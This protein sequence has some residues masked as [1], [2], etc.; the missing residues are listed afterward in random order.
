MLVRRFAS[1]EAK[2]ENIKITPLYDL[3]KAFDGRMVDFAG[4]DLPVYYQTGILNEHN[5]TRNL[6]SLFDVSHMAQA[7]IFGNAEA[8][9]KIF[10]ADLVNMDIGQLRYNFLLNDAGGIVDDLMITRKSNTHWG[11]IVNAACRNK[12]FEYLANHF[13]LEPHGDLGLLA[14]QGPKASEVIGELNPDIK[15]LKFM[16]STEANLAGVSVFIS[17]SG[18]TGEDGYEISVSQENCTIL[19]RT[20]LENENVKLAGLGARDSLRLEAGLCLYGTDIDE[21]TSPLEAG[22]G[23]AIAQ[24]RKLE[25]GFKGAKKIQQ[26]LKEGITR[27]RIGI[28]IKE[29]RPC[30]A[31]AVLLDEKGCEIGHITSGSIAAS[32]PQPIAMGYI[33]KDFAKNGSAI[34][35]LQR[36]KQIAAEITKLPFRPHNYF[37]KKGEKNE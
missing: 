25:G 4:Y 22:L 8:L 2:T 37:L 31:G 10:P 12:D 23:W 20:L 30:R 17:R 11:V 5:Q 26:Q 32:Y 35:V 16:T 33:K 7:S 1:V 6:A 15:N 29:K 21:T 34:T 28:T 24:R 36:D 3:H 27:R 18:Y 14:L 9:E 19:A 13:R